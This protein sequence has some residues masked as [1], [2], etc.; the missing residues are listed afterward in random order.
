M[1]I[2]IASDHNGHALRRDLVDWLAEEGHVVE[3]LA[4]SDPMATVDY[5]PICEALARAVIRGDA[6]RAIMIGGTGSGEAVACNK[7]AGIRAGL[8]HRVFT[9]R[10]S[11]ANNDS[12]VLILGAKLI[13][14]DLAREITATWLTTPFRGGHHARRLEQIRVLEEGGTLLD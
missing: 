5:P 1:R 3:D 14:I 9:A 7:L 6:D 8:C 10:I 4:P 11:R 13:G 12:N 2:V